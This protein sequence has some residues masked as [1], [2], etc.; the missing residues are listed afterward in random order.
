MEASFPFPYDLTIHPLQFGGHSF[1]IQALKDVEATIDQIFE[2]LN[3]EN[4]PEYLEELCPYFGSIWAAAVGLSQYLAHVPHSELE[5]L[6]TLELGCGLALPSIVL[7]KRGIQTV[8]TDKHPDVP[9]F[10]SLNLALNG[11][12]N[13]VAYLTVDWAKDRKAILA[14]Q[15]RNW[16]MGSDILYESAH[17]KQIAEAIA[18]QV[19]PSTEKVLIADPGRSYLQEFS[20]L[21]SKLLGR[22]PE[23]RVE[24]CRALHPD[25]E[26][27]IL[28]F[29]LI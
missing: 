18:A 2:V 22:S 1:Q 26:I 27:F 21:M 12:E 13:R 9:R 29:D 14:S 4:R 8:C 24:R 11:L 23:V 5:G 15:G 6:K 10:L 28:E 25:K 17:P 16:V 20:D 3:R 19:G 7:A